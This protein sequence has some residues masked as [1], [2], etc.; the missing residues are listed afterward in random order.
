RKR[1]LVSC[2]VLLVLTIPV[3]MSLPRSV[4]PD[5]DQGEFRARVELPRGTPLEQTAEHVERLEE[6]IR[7]DDAVDVVFSRIGRQ[8]AVVG[9]DEEHSGL[10]TALL[11]VRLHPGNTTRAVLERLRPKLAALPTGSV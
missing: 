11:E 3:A 2:F 6:L 9:M 7:E 10:N 4:L 5:V 1:V 8:A